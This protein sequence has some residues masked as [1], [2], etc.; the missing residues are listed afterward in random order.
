[1]WL[2]MGCVKVKSSQWGGFLLEFDDE[3]V[4]PTLTQRAFPV[5]VEHVEAPVLG[6]VASRQVHPTGAASSGVGEAP[7]AIRAIGGHTDD[8]VVPSPPD[9]RT[10]R[11]VVG[12]ADGGIHPGHIVEPGGMVVI[13]PL[14]R[15]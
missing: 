9:G 8:L 13:G 15:R 5:R 6:D 1:M 14:G 2:D 3:N 12:Q 11:S 4:C 7:D 10:I